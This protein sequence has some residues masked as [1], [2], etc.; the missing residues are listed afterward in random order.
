MILCDGHEYWANIDFVAC[1][2]MYQLSWYI[3]IVGFL[4]IVLDS[5]W[6]ANLHRFDF[7]FQVY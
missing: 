1:R 7:A 5:Q 4:F 3:E 2:K 6:K